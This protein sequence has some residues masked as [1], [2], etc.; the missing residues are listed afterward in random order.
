[1]TVADYLQG[2]MG[3]REFGK[4]MDSLARITVK[5]GKKRG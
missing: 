3:K 1:M 5:E 2:K 4:L